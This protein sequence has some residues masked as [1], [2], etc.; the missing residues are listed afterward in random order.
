MAGLY[1]YTSQLPADMLNGLGAVFVLVAAWPVWRRFGAAYAV[2]ILINILPPMAAGGLLSVGRF[3]SVLFP[4]FIWFASGRSGAS[5]SRVDRGVHGGAG[6][7]RGAVLHLA[8]TVLAIR[9]HAPFR[10]EFPRKPSDIMW[11]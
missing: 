10:P 4:A 9:A 6:F 5:P 7:Q 11:R 1:G 3:S 8:R 2:F